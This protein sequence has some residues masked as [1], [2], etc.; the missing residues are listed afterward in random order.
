MWFPLALRNLTRNRR[1]T[2]LTLAVIALGTSMGF[3]LSGYTSQA[4]DAVKQG[5][6]DQYAHLQIASPLLWEDDNLGADAML[7]PDRL[8]ELGEAL[9]ARPEVAAHSPEMVLS[10]MASTA[11]KAKVIDLVAFVP[12]NAALDYNALV[13]QGKLLDASARN[14]VLVGRS[15]AQELSIA[16]GDYLRVTTSTLGGSYNQ[17]TLQ[18][19]GI[20]S[21]NDV[22]DESQLAFV[23]LETGQSLLKTDGVN[24]VAVRL[25]DVEDTAAVAAGLNAD[26]ASP[27]APLAVRSWDQ[28]SVYYQQTRGFFELLFSFLMVAISLLVFFI[29]F[30]VLSMSF[31]ERTREVGTIRAIGTKRRQIFAMFLLES[32]M[33]ALLGGALGLAFGWASGGAFNALELGWTPPGALQPLP[34][35]V[36]LSW[37]AAWLPLLISAAATLLSALYPTVH[38]SRLNIVNALR[39][40]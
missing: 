21:R 40:N 32:L 2:L 11:E 18:V 16:P 24:K 4:L 22:Q 15:L 10:A 12:G 37:S 23:P 28:L 8:A 19:V 3:H 27:E 34:V 25:H 39:A 14:P 1:R 6:I 30:Q 33:L 13:V 38:A 31:L 36:E 20:Y 9:S 35:Q 17:E 5:A 7:P 26:L 29:V